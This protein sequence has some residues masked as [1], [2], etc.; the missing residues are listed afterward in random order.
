MKAYLVLA[1]LTTTAMFGV[2]LSLPADQS[3]GVSIQAG[4]EHIEFRA[5]K[6]LVARYH[7][8]PGVAKP[9]FYPVNA[10]GGVPLTRGWPMEKG[11][12]EE[13]T[14]HVHQKSAW[15]CH[16]D[17]IPEGVEIKDKI[18]GVEGADFW[19]ENKGHGRMVCT[20][21][22]VPKV[23]KNHGQITTRNEWQTSDGIKIMNETR[24]IHLHDFGEARL[25]VCA[26]DLQAVVPVTFGDTKEGSFG[27][28]INDQIREQ[29]G[30]GRL[31]N[32]EGKSTEKECW[33]QVSAWCD[34]SGP[35]DGKAVGLA[36]LA[37]PS[38]PHP[39][40][41]H[42]RGYGLMAANPFGRSKAGFPAMRG[43]TDLVRLEKGEHLKLRYGMLLHAGDVKEGKVAEYFDRFVKLKG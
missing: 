9:Y 37:D 10:P 6:D 31:T 40:C 25:L 3:D 43:K 11:L 22:D 16:G 29:K 33:G 34:Y 21:V 30:K 5:G 17:V 26:I 13:T 24:T 28:R 35:I 4:K 15:F 2:V 8:A 32:A 38:N 36:I 42:S 12:P 14:D 19:S 41:W 23:G 27:I 1:L 7:I 18:R 39:T 20:D